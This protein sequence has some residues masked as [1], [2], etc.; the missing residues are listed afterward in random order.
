M[1]VWEEAWKKRKASK[2][3]YIVARR[4]CKH[5][6]CIAKKDA[7]KKKFACIKQHDTVKF[8]KFLGK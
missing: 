6:V 8:S 2:K 5:T 7:E 4:A 3:E 1:S